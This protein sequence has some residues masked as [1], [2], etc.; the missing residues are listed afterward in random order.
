MGAATVIINTLVLEYINKF[1][2]KSI[3]RI[4]RFEALALE[5]NYYWKG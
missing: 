2:E 5:K 1:H 4:K 3:D